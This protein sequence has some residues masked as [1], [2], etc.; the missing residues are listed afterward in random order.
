MLSDRGTFFSGGTYIE[1]KPRCYCYFF[2]IGPVFAV[3]SFAIFA[4]ILR[5][6]AE[7]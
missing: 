7:C 5:D 1:V 2:V 6:E 4:E 3:I